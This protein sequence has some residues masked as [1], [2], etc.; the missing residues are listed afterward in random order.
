[1]IALMKLMVRGIL[2]NRVLVIVLVLT[3]YWMWRLAFRTELRFS[4][5]MPAEIRIHGEAADIIELRGS[6][7]VWPWFILLVAAG[8]VS[9]L[10]PRMMQRG[11]I[12][13]ILSKPLTRGKI[14]L[15][16]FLVS[17]G[18]LAANFG[19]LFFFVWLAWGIG[20]GLWTGV[21]LLGVAAWALSGC[22]VAV[23]GLLFG[24]I[25]GKG[26]LTAVLTILCG[27]VLPSLL[28]GRDK[29]FYPVSG[30]PAFRWIIDAL[31]MIL[32]RTSECPFT[33]GK[34][35]AGIPFTAEPFVATALST[36]AVFGVSL[37]LFQKKSF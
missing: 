34:A 29:V 14:L 17:A 26:S 22:A 36:I 18:M 16:A 23:V 1:M 33:V 35:I 15:A 21:L 20:Q 24:T 8:G 37:V 10:L 4:E 7:T 32:P 30:H 9:T 12:E 5:G 6:L 27:V 3:V 2:A 19:L 28:E 31:Y 11:R 25:T 13:L